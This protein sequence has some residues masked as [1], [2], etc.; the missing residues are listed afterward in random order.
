[1]KD[2]SVFE[3][4]KKYLRDKSIY[5]SEGREILQEIGRPSIEYIWVLTGNYPR[6]YETDCFTLGLIEENTSLKEQLASESNFINQILKIT[7]HV[8]LIKKTLFDEDIQEIIDNI[9]SVYTHHSELCNEVKEWKDENKKLEEQNQRYEK[10]LK[11]ILSSLN[12]GIE[13]NTRLCK[14]NRI[15]LQALSEEHVPA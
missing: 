4:L 5:F 11:E 15:A 10:A 9:S 2:K 3:E 7:N 12:C 1:M 6:I 8:D 13:G 14:P